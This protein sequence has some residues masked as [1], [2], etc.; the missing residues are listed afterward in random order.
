MRLTVLPI[1]KLPG[2]RLS[3]AREAE[4]KIRPWKNVPE[5]VLS[6]FRNVWLAL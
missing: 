1:E 3:N 2:Q 6:A 4:R 5:N